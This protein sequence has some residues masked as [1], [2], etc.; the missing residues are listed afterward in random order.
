MFYIVYKTT[1]LVNNKIYVGVH[2]TNDIDDGYLG[3]GKVLRLAIEKYGKE[4]FVREILASFDNPEDMMKMEA[5]VV[6]E[7]FLK[8]SDV[9]NVM[10]GGKGGFDYINENR[11]NVYPTHSEVNR[12]KGKAFSRFMKEKWLDPEFK[13]KRKEAISSGLKTH[14]VNNS[15]NFKN[16]LH[17]DEAKAKIGKANSALQ[18]GEKNSQYGTMWIHLP[19]EKISKKIRSN[20]LEYYLSIGWIRGRTQKY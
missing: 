20:E 12:R 13:E 11:L 15:G 16:K 1:N 6:N 10:Q 2:K 4:N 19:T 3:S 18:S 5:N 7:D 8:R 17:T 14:F 9:Y